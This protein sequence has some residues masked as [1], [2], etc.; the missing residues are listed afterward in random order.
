VMITIWWSLQPESVTLTQL[1]S[2]F[3]SHDD[4]YEPSPSLLGTYTRPKRVGSA[5]RFIPF[6]FEMCLQDDKMEGSTLA[7]EDDVKIGNQQQP[8]EMLAPRSANMTAERRLCGPGS[9]DPWQLEEMDINLWFLC[10]QTV[11]RTDMY[12][13]Y[14]TGT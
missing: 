9:S 12:M 1:Q 6:K 13:L 11:F 3:V 8:V 10:H 14:M 5:G 7:D 4:R 2:A